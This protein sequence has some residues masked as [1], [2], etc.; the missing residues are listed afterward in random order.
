MSINQRGL[1]CSFVEV[2][3][4][5]PELSDILAFFFDQPR[6]P[7]K[8]FNPDDRKT[9][10]VLFDR[11]TRLSV[12]KKSKEGGA[13][14]AGVENEGQGA[15]CVAR[16]VEHSTGRSFALCHVL[17]RILLRLGMQNYSTGG[18]AGKPWLNVP[19][20]PNV[21]LQAAIASHMKKRIQGDYKKC[22]STL[23]V[24]AYHNSMWRC[25]SLCAG[26]RPIKS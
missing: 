22:R 9:V 14:S 26:Q 21:G 6:I 16:D 10:E 18:A 24:R 3:A 1:P 23:G 7:T 5:G 20:T 25:Q 12:Q 11:V 19:S 17:M 8:M 15:G 13:E 4:N 2:K